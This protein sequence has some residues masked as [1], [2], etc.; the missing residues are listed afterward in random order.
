[1]ILGTEGWDESYGYALGNPLSA[2]VYTPASH[3][4]P[5]TLV[6]HFESGT[7]VVFTYSDGPDPE[8][9]PTGSGAIWW[10]RP[11]H[12]RVCH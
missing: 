9:K 3:P 8:G 1:M 2:A 12:G 4:A 7:K 6:R 11:S 10:G 5:A